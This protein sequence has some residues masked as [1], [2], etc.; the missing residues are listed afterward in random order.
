[1]TATHYDVIIIGAGAAG[2]MCAAEAQKRHRTTLIIEKANKPGRKILMSGGGKCNFTNLHIRPEAFISGNPHFVKSPLSRYTQWDFI[3]QVKKHKIPYHEKKLGQLF[4]DRSSKDIVTMLLNETKRVDMLYNTNIS[5]IKHH[6]A[7]QNR[8]TVHASNKTYHCH[9]LVIATGGLSIPSMGTTPFAYNIAEQFNITVTPLRAALVPFTLHPQDKEKT[10]AISGT[11]AE[12]RVS[13]SKMHFHEDMLFTH[14][15]LSGPAMLQ[16]SS[17]WIPGQPL[18]IDLSPNTE[19][20]T[21]L[22]NAKQTSPNSKIKSVLKTLLAKSIVESFFSIELLNQ[23]VAN[24][25]TN[26]FNQIHQTLK[27]WQVVPS[28]TEG[29]R[30]AEVTLGGIDTSELSQ[31]SMEAKKTPGLFFIGEA[32]DVTGWLGGYNF[33]WAWSSGW[34]AGQEV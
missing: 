17:Y 22:Q 2:L 8:F 30:T 11:S 4:C 7:T 9:S 34:A 13:C 26:T 29:Y 16:I 5:H 28:G 33:Q 1:M 19:I 18:S 32:V 24:A 10:S 3:E 23:N 12:C 25:S 21:I 27:K 20:S 31:R 15:G 14:R 6:T